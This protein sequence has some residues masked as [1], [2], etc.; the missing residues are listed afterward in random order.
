MKTKI[1]CAG[2]IESSCDDETGMRS[3][4]FLQGCKKNCA[5][6]QNVRIREHGK[7]KVIEIAELVKR[8]KRE[9][10]NKKITISGG[11]PLEQMEGL[12]KLVE[13]LK[14]EEFNI[15][16]Y[17]GWKL[18]AVPEILIKNIDFLKTGEFIRELQ[19]EKLQYMGSSNQH[20]YKI[21]DGKLTELF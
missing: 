8:I 5:G 3:V 1:E 17:T 18:E 9:C 4:L 12:L 10:Y 16:I 15:C 7:G 20:M 21:K 2:F 14:K 19:H 6:C 11:E 13:A